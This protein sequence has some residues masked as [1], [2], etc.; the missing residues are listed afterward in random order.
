M[1][2]DKISHYGCCHGNGG[3]D[4]DAVMPS[5]VLFL[6]SIFGR[7]CFVE[8]TYYLARAPI[9]KDDPSKGWDILGVL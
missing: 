7:L 9:L 6:L 4:G 5:S 2:I 8:Y 3:V 1:A